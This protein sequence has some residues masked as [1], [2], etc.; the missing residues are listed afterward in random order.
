MF[1]S[2]PALGTAQRIILPLLAQRSPLLREWSCI[3]ER[4]SHIIHEPI[5]SAASAFA[6]ILTSPKL[7]HTI[8]LTL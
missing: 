3:G 2:M 5:S 4:N 6:S 1:L 7:P 8:P